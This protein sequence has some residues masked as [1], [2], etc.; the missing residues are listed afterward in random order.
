MILFCLVGSK[1]IKEVQI[2]MMQSVDFEAF[3]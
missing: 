3:M 1:K 2:V